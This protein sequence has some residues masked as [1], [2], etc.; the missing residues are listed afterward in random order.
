MLLWASHIAL[1]VKKL[2]ANTGDAGLIPALR[3]SPVGGHSN[4]VFLPGEPHGWRSMADYSTWVHK[5][6]D[7]AEVTSLLPNSDL[8]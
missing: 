7:T 6:L 5:E 3:R 2:P 4:P 8:N 1:V